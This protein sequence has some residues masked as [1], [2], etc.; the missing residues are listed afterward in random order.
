MLKQLKQKQKSHAKY[1]GQ[2]WDI[3]FFTLLDTIAV[4][5]RFLLNVLERTLLVGS[6]LNPSIGE[7]FG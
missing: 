2:Q 6:H 7:N 3:N 5:F 4:H 1:T